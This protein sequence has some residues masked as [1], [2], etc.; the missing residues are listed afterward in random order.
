MII[1][2]SIAL[3]LIAAML[4]SLLN[5]YQPSFARPKVPAGGPLLND[6]GL[7]VE[8]VVSGL[9]APTSLSFLG[10]NEILVTEKNT[11]IVQV[12]QNGVISKEPL[13]R[14]NVSKDDERGLLG[15]A[16]SADKKTIFLYY[17]EQ[18]PNEGEITN[19]V[20]LYD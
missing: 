9:K 13:I 16:L 5:Y 18:R 20:Y 8:L 4:S 19:N 17:T 6:P 7:K 2:S 1:K 3:I 11:G 15:I 12:V 14:L 10:P